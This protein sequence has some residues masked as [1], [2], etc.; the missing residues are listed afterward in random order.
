[1][2]EVPDIPTAPLDL[3]VRIGCKPRYETAFAVPMLL[4]VKPP[5]DIYQLVAHA[6]RHARTPPTPALA[7]VDGSGGVTL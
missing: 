2:N 5:Q 3:A 4:N 1:M 6:L 7:C